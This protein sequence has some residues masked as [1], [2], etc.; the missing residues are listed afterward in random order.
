MTFK[1]QLEAMRACKE[2]TDWVGARDAATA[3]QECERSDWMLWL[4]CKHPPEKR[5]LV[6]IAC[7]IARTALR[8][9]RDGE[10]RP[11]LAIEAAERWVAD[12]TE[13]NRVASRTA[14]AYAAAA[15]AADA[16]YAAAAE[17]SARK[18]FADIIR[19]HVPNNPV[20]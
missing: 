5:V 3:W 12:P 20:Q 10:E 1:K 18:Q 13:D 19:K 9:V 8:F 16:A 6:S 2:A 7:D 11:R 17:A 4:L 15:A 14:Y